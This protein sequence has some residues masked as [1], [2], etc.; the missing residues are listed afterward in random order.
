[1]IFSSLPK[2]YGFNKS[3]EAGPDPFAPSIFLK[4]CQLRCPYCMNSKLVIGKN[5]NIIDLSTIKSFVKDNGCKWVS[6]SGGEPLFS[7]GNQILSL[8]NEIRKWGCNIALSTNGLEPEKLSMVI[9]LLGYVTLDI[10]TDSGRYSS[11]TENGE[12]NVF[13]K[14]VST[15]NRLKDRKS[16]LMGISNK[17][18][19]EI[20]T[21]LY[22]PLVDKDAIVGIGQ[23]LHMGE[24]EKWVLQPFRKTKTMLSEAAYNV[25]EYG[26]EETQNLFSIAKT[27]TSKVYIREV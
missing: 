9:S 4:A 7:P 5:E 24:A 8:L 3:S 21:T 11:I 22:P 14:V 1:M 17:F 26:E 12:K 19:Y 23:Q 27:Y 16:L 2:I 15:L 18:D 10:K 6:I 25:T 13:G 20:R